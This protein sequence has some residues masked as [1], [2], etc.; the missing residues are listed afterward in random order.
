MKGKLLT[1]I[2]YVITFGINGA[3][4]QILAVEKPPVKKID[5]SGTV[6]TN[7]NFYATNR[8]YNSA[9]PFAVNINANLH[10]RILDAVDVPFSFTMGKYQNSFSNPFLQFS[11]SPRYKWA[12][13]H[14]GNINLTFNPYTLAGLSFWGVGTELNP[15]KFRF[16]AM[17][18]MLSPAVEIDTTFTNSNIASFKRMGYGVKIGYGTNSNFIDLIYFHAKDDI[19]SIKSWQDLEIQKFM[20]DAAILTPQENKVIGLSSKA[21]IIKKLMFTVDGGVTFLNKNIADTLFDKP[22]GLNISN[23]AIVHYAGKA[24]W[25][26]SFKNLFLSTN[27]EHV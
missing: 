10:M 4:C 27:Y 1:L 12:N 15:G 23:D 21:T 22:K 7:M 16:S 2:F 17:Y 18:G 9:N 3:K 19:H 5:W 26:Y 25:G 8:I 6:G 13:L 20:G 14:A 11:I 24:S